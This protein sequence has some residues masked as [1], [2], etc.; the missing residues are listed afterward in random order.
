MK[1][2]ISN[3]FFGLAIKIYNIL[4]MSDNPFSR[5][6]IKDLDL[7][8]ETRKPIEIIKDE[9]TELKVELIHI[10]NYIRKL[11]AREQIKE[12]K[13]KQV[14]AEYEKVSKGWFY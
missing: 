13:E 1:H 4:K 14:E 6:V 3:Y 11:E 7:I 5:Q 2:L 9:L 10:K 8:I 12:E